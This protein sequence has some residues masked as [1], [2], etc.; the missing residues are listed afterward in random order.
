MHQRKA[1]RHA[2]VALLPNATDAGDRVEDT[3]TDPIRKT[4]PLPV[5]SV[6]TPS[7]RVDRE[8]STPREEKHDLE[9]KIEVW[10]Q[11]T[12]VRKVGDAMD[13]LSEQIEAVMD[14][15]RYLA[16]LVGGDGVVL[17]DTNMEVLS[18]RGAD[19][20]IGIATLTYSMTYFKVIGATS[21]IVDD[22]LRTGATT[23]IGGAGDDNTVRDLFNQRP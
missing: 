2:V 15:D 1:I 16:G 22:Y 5:I 3:R 18:E 13:D 11:D 23:K 19:P 7:D 21:P 12:T 8:H 20:L 10:V 6:Y 9:L 14:V 4:E 17:D